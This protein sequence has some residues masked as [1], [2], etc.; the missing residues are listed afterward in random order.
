M[1]TLT[2]AIPPAA[3]TALIV[4]KAVI[5]ENERE[6]KLPN[7]ELGPL[8][9]ASALSDFFQLASALEQS[10]QAMEKEEISELAGYA[11]DLLDRL[12]FQLRE[13]NILDQRENIARV[14]ATMAVWFARRGAVLD[15]LQGAADGLAWLTNGMD[16][17]AELVEMCLMMEE[18]V[19]AA[20][21]EQATDEDKTNPW[22]PWRVLNLNVGVAATRALDPVLMARVFDDL[23]ERLPAD[24]PGFF[25]DGKRQ[26]DE[27]NVPD[28]VRE[29]LDTYVAKYPAAPMH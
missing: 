11:L 29:V 8:V 18:V 5:D 23:V 28:A 26:M 19:E 25:A 27:Q 1:N 3:D 10:D 15:N 20:S 2:I 12:S 14:C 4:M 21:A 24:A 9:L 7:D 22:R 16:K 13:L 17:P 6:H